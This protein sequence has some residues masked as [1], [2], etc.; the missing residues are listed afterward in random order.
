MKKII[1]N[2]EMFKWEGGYGYVFQA[3]EENNEEVSEE[4]FKK[5]NIITDIDKLHKYENEYTFGICID[6]FE[7]VE[8]DEDG[9]EEVTEVIG[10]DFDSAELIFN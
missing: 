9:E 6:C 2:R 4:N 8:I 10:Y 5:L 1:K 3:S 7:L